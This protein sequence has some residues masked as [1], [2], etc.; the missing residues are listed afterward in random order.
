MMKGFFL[1]LLLLSISYAANAKDHVKDWGNNQSVL[2]KDAEVV[3]DEGSGWYIIKVH[4]QCF[5]IR[6]LNAGHAGYM[7]MA[8]IECPEPD[9]K[10]KLR[11]LT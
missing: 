2:P 6:V 4:K 11:P 9:T 7:A 1:C 5:L 3:T 10:P 8:P